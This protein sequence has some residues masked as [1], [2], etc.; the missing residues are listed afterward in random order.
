MSHCLPYLQNEQLRYLGLTHDCVWLDDLGVTLSIV[1]VIIMFIALLVAAL[2]EGNNVT[3]SLAHGGKGFEISA[4]EIINTNPEKFQNEIFAF[5]ADIFK[6][7]NY[8]VVESH[9]PDYLELL[10]RNAFRWKQTT[11][12]I[13]LNNINSKL[14]VNIVVSR[15]WSAI[16]KFTSE[17]IES[18]N[19]EFDKIISDIK[20]L[21]KD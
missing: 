21:I 18:F 5:I 12:K 8:S 16:G 9:R 11:Y 1:F 14:V 13:S 10:K 20:N 2:R 6:T 15:P 19:K 17:E 3:G 7:E 4:R